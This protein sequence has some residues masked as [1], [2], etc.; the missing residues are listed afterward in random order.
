VKV[1][2]EFYAK[3]TSSNKEVREMYIE[4]L[5]R[6]GQYN[7]AFKEAQEIIKNEPNSPLALRTFANEYFN[8][9]QYAKAI[10]AFNKLITV[11]T[12]EYDDYRLLGY[13]YSK[14]KKDSLAAMTWEEIV[15]D[16]AQSI[17]TRSFF[18]GEIGGAWMR[19][20]S[21]DC[22]ANAFK[23]RMQLDPNAVGAVINYGQ[24]LIQLGRYDEALAAFKEAREK[25]PNYPPIYNNLGYCYFQM[26]DYDAGRREYETAIKVADTAEFKYRYE[27]A[28]AYRMI[29]LSIM[30]KKETDPDASKRKWESAVVY[31]KKSLK[32]KEDFSQ[33]HF[34][35]GKCYQNLSKLEDAVR[36]YKRA[37]KLD[38]TNKEALKLIEELQKYL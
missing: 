26:K 8:K 28:D 30:L 14:T 15:K 38:P 6:N 4:A 12:L 5:L 7:E 1:L 13:A 33:T 34:L 16:T 10:E 36:E 18:L 31:L 24:N 2:E 22:A 32:Y 19:D 17:M 11:D 20:R 29:G 3:C 25:N 21:Y 35:L 27:L 23:R 37:A 9:Q